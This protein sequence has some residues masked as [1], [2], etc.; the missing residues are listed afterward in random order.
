MK[1]AAFYTLGCRANQHQTFCLECQMSNPPAG[2]AGD[3][4]Q[5]V[6]FNE[7]AD[8]YIINTCTVTY[9]AERKSRQAIRRAIRQNPKAKIIVTGCYSKLEPDKLLKE[10]SQIE[11]ID[12]PSLASSI[13][14]LGPQIRA[15]LMIQDGCEHFCSY[16]IVP[17][18]RGKIKSK[19]LRQVIEEANQLVKAGAREIV[20][21]GINLG[22]Y[23]NDLATVI[24]H[25]ASI[26]NLLRIRLSSLEP[27]YIKKEL[28]DSIAQNPKVCQHL[29]LPLQSGNND[30][31]KSMNRNYSSAHYF[32]LVNYIREK[33]PD[34]GITT[35]VI[36]GFPG[37]GNKEFQQ[38][39]DLIGK[40]K[41]SR[42]HVFSYS[43]R[44]GTAAADF[45][46]QV[47]EKT[48][49][50]RNKTLRKLGTR[51]MVE[52][53]N[54]YI[55]KQVEILVEQA[56]TGITRNYIRVIYHKKEGEVGQLRL[57]KINQVLPDHCLAS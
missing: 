17:Y 2:R 52:F 34:C 42:L 23:E 45:S 14:P 30:I 26:K 32:D 27:M 33:M 54:Q 24:R 19:P 38:T 51:L 56:G 55:N 15:N 7:T 18:A 22:T 10:F 31:L 50:T 6:N 48:K 11:I 12:V 4:C 47:D 16:C 37:E 5:I 9:D 39:V 44:K 21:T 25:L 3:K 46:N 57:L 8:I 40:I 36:V 43:K 1:K 28:I 20:L 29:H 35:D 53:A 41:F 13:Q 49:K